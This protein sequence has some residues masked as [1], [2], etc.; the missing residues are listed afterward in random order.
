MPQ[1]SSGGYFPNITEGW[2]LDLAPKNFL[3][4]P[5]SRCPQ[6]PHPEAVPG[7]LP[8]D[9]PSPGGSMEAL[10]GPLAAGCWLTSETLGAGWQQAALAIPVPVLA[11]SLGITSAF[12]CYWL[13]R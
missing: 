6:K 8:E 4:R 2:V 5:I 1:P 7:M 12:Y 13:Q 10:A 9:R 11:S 3:K